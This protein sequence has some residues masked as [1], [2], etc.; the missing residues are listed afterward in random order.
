MGSYHYLLHRTAVIG[1]NRAS[2]A[3]TNGMSFAHSLVRNKKIYATVLLLSL[4][5]VTLHNTLSERI[6]TGS[7]VLSV[8]DL[9]QIFELSPELGTSDDNAPISGTDLATA[10]NASIAMEAL[11]PS[12]TTLRSLVFSP[13][14]KSDVQFGVDATAS[15][16]EK[17][18]EILEKLP[19][20]LNDVAF[21]RTKTAQATELLRAEKL[22]V[23]SDL[24]LSSKV[25]A[26]L[27]SAIEQ[28]KVSQI[29][30]DPISTLE[31]ALALE[32]KHVLVQQTLSEVESGLIHAFTKARIES[33]P[34]RPRVAMNFVFWPLLA[35][36]VTAF[37]LAA[38]PSLGKR[39]S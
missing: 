30:F 7:L 2:G 24:L 37:S 36:F 29:A 1:L 28:N 25:R 6:Y 27:K 21:L 34:I 16:K 9:T 17:L 35:L 14:R 19:S 23:E 3:I 22:R 12:G 39:N 33:D 31:S 13:I 38:F 15:D 10:F 5:A 18:R 4:A 11:D 20:V 32:R 26:H 8:T